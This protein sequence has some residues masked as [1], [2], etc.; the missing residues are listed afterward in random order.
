M[1]VPPGTD[2]RD[3]LNSEIDALVAGG[4]TPTPSALRAAVN[5][6][7]PGAQDRII[8]LISD[9]QS[10]CG[11]PCPV[12]QQLADEA[13]VSFTAYTVGF[14]ATDTAEDELACIA[15]V[16]GGQ[17]YPASDEEGL[18]DAINDAV[19]GS[20]DYVAI[21]DSTTT[22][23]SIPDCDG[24]RVESE[25][26]CTGPPTATPYPERIESSADVG[27]LERKGIWGDTITRTVEAY[28][29]GS[30]APNEP[31]EPQLIAAEKSTELVTM[32]L[33]AN[34][35][36]W[37]D[38]QAWVSSCVGARYVEFFGRRIARG[39]E[40]REQTCREEAEDRVAAF[41]D[42]LSTAMDVLDAAAD[43][44]AQVVVTQYYNPFND[45]KQ[46]QRWGP[47]PDTDRDCSQLH[48]MAQIIIDTLNEELGDQ[49]NAH[50]FTIADLRP[51]FDGRGAGSLEPY[52]F[53]VDCELIGAGS[54][55][56]FDLRDGVDEDGSI[57]NLG[58]Q[59][60]PHPND[61]GTT[62]QAETI[63]EVLQ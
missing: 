25:Y 59:F 37:S 6:F 21:G 39:L 53:G 48:T 5:D 62:A 60:D 4:G 32:S 3:A 45:R 2:N 12:A 28:H 51:K 55:I 42:E 11:D 58:E 50:G 24:D 47:I 35:M 14:Q 8:V 46:I 22:G 54:A 15:E 36:Q 31:W 38:I 30:N 57:E 23:F 26:G 52:V 56:D 9:G 34:D 63:L 49:A 33:G 44:G 16:T 29:N 10:T 19:G 61:A 7:A 18:A 27:T 41:A 20:Y 1:R 43:R 17:Y 40:I 13:D